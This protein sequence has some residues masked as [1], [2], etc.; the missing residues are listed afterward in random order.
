VILL[1]QM[2]RNI[3]RGT[4]G[5][6]AQDAKALRVAKLSVLAGHDL[7]VP[8]P[9]RGFFY[10]PFMHAEDVTEQERSIALYGRMP[11]P[12]KSMNMSFA[13]SHRDAIARFG[14]F[15]GRNEVRG[16]ASTPEEEAFNKSSAY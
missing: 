11:E 8:P 14:R 9:V 1:D 2:P 6:F 3:H 13:L 10:L 5:M 15:P 12:E 4:P 7:K 16:I